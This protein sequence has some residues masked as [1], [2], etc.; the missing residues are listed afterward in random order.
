MRSR[1]LRTALLY[2]GGGV[3]TAYDVILAIGQ[4]NMCG[5]GAH[6]AAI[7]VLSDGAK[8]FGGY[9]S[10]ANFRKI[11]DIY[12]MEMPE[13]VETGSHSPAEDFAKRYYQNTGRRALIVP[14]AWGGTSLVSIAA[15]NAPNPPQWKVNG[16]LYN[17]A[18]SQAN[19]AIA[20]AQIINPASKFVGCIWIQGETDGDNAITQ[21]AYITEFNAMLAGI[22]AGVTGAA[23]SWFIIGSMM[24][25]A[26]RSYYANYNRIHSAHLSAVLKNTKIRFVQGPSGYQKDSFHYLAPGSRILGAAMADAIASIDTQEVSYDF[27]QDVVGNASIMGVGV[28]GSGGSM[29]IDNTTRIGMSGKYLTSTA[30]TTTSGQFSAAVFN[31]ANMDMADTVIEWTEAVTSN[32][33]RTGMTLRAG[34][35]VNSNGNGRVG[36]LFQTNGSGANSNAGTLKI[37]RIDGAS[38]AALGTFTLASVANRRYRA[39]AIGT[40][41]KFEYSDNDGATWNTA[42]TATD[43]TYSN[44][45]VQYIQ[46]F[47]ATL[48]GVA[49]IDNIKIR[50]A[51]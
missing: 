45:G 41:L 50:K 22:R 4:S 26:V 25:E 44:G 14:C 37:Y 8:Q 12:P 20:A 47:A 17:N 29:T 3:D 13:K 46:G 7:D 35:T 19:A 51:I 39:S 10:G 23:N 42:I 31:A 32:Q 49:A 30:L 9:S 6:D 21:A 40:A 27:E 24:P 38:A 48:A 11:I 5:R 43:S 2:S 16:S 28:G 18:I 33:F 34:S 15:N 36:Y 1:Y